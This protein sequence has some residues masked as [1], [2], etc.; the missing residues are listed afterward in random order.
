MCAK[1][2]LSRPLE[3]SMN[4]FK[5]ELIVLLI[6]QTSLLFDILPLIT[7]RDILRRGKLKNCLWFLHIES[8]EI[9]YLLNSHILS[10]DFS[11]HDSAS[12]FKCLRH[13]EM[14]FT[15]IEMLLF[16]V[17][18]GFSNTSRIFKRTN[19]ISERVY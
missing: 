11:H 12:I 17:F 8:P 9:K 13:R 14:L 1:K 10:T 15:I 5:E 4:L 19:T 16:E 3:H 2:P 18:I 7:D 6:S